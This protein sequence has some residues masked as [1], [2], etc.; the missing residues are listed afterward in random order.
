MSEEEKALYNLLSLEPVS[1]DELIDRTGFPAQKVLAALAYLE[2]K[3]FTRQM[4]GKLYIR[5]D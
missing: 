5:A 3:G 2:I 4:P 1:L